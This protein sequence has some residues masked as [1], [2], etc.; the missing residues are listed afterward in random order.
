MLDENFTRSLLEDGSN[1]VGVVDVV[2]SC[3]SGSGSPRIYTRVTSALGWI[4]SV[5]DASSC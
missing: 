5:T 4:M 2:L 3:L 1:L